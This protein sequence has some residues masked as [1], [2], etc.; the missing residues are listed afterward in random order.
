MT[1]SRR[2]FGLARWHLSLLLAVLA[3]VAFVAALALAA[4]TAPAAA[5][6]VPATATPVAA[7]AEGKRLFTAKGCATCHV[8]AALAGGPG[9][10][11]EGLTAGPTQTNH[12]RDAA[13]LR[14]LL[15]DPALVR[16]STRDT[17]QMPNLNLTPAEIEAL[18]AFLT[19]D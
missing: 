3:G 2:R 8:H 7:S 16:G 6:P 11:F 4:Q 14:V 9:R 5:P 17:F 12:G 15:R 1:A 10:P 13:Y 19:E 18:V